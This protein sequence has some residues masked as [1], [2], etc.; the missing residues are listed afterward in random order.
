MSIYIINVCLLVYIYYRPRQK[1]VTKITC[2][3]MGGDII[4]WKEQ[5]KMEEKKTAN[6]ISCS[7]ELQQW[8]NK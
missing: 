8:Y 1:N 6:I 4:T 2:S 3:D 7:P 5:D